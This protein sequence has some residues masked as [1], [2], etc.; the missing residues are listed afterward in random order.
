M[1]IDTRRDGC[2]E[3]NSV[4]SRMLGKVVLFLDRLLLGCVP[5]SPG[6]LIRCHQDRDAA[7]RARGRAGQA[8]MLFTI[9]NPPVS[10]AV[11]RPRN[12]QRSCAAHKLHRGTIQSPQRYSSV[13]T[14]GAHRAIASELVPEL[15]PYPYV[16]ECTRMETGSVGDGRR[17]TDGYRGV[18]TREVYRNLLSR[19]S[20][21]SK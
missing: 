18:A 1:I 21:P 15:V 9:R 5:L 20:D 16:P 3:A 14:S 8:T 4:V 10:H 12:A 17:T 13:P 19:T 6:S 11:G 2:A 7:I